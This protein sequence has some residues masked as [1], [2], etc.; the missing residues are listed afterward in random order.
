[1]VTG[2]NLVTAAAIAKECHILEDTVDLSNP[3]PDDLE[4]DPDL[5]GDPTKRDEHIK[6][7]IERRPK[8]LTGN[9][10]FTAI[11]GLY[12]ESCGKDTNECKCAKTSAEAEAK[13][14]EL[15][16]KGQP[17]EDIPVRNETI[18]DEDMKTFKAL[19]KN[20]R[21][22][23]RSQPIHKYA[24]VLGLRKLGYVVGVTGKS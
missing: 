13:K 11:H 17:E 1:M 5:T 18:R 4:E 3:K 16:L 21:V 22:M 10:F 7:V 24:L 6:Q 2:D 20:L 8:A 15:K 19:T 9:T 12:C 14:E 23:A